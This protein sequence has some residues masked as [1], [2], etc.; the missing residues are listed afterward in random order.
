MHCATAGLPVR[1]TKVFLAFLG[2]FETKKKKARKWLKSQLLPQRKHACAQD[3][4][5]AGLSE[6]SVDLYQITRRHVPVDISRHFL[7][8]V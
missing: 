5:F 2:T 4:D 3:I 7:S 6:P 1:H 8:T